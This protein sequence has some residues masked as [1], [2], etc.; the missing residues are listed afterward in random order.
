MEDGIRGMYYYVWLEEI[1]IQSNS[2]AKDNGEVLYL[3]K[4]QHMHQ[5]VISV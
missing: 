5:Y 4:S 3:S 2:L 1:F